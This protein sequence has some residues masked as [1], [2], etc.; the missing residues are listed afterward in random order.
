MALVVM[1]IDRDKLP[2]HTNEQ[3]EEWVMFQVGQR[4]S[5]S[6][7]NPLHDLDME[8]TVREFSRS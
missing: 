4:G 6:M 5:V 1:S 2:A 8:A 7:E 3:F